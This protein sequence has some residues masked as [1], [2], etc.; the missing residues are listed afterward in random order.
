MARC[1]LCGGSLGGRQCI[2][3]ERLTP[4]EEFPV[5]GFL[6]LSLGLFL[7]LQGMYMNWV[8]TNTYKNRGDKQD[9][10]PAPWTWL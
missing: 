10:P 2:C 5:V 1:S 4:A 6:L 7:F 9:S 3:N 8:A